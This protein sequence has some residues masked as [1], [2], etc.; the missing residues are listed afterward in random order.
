[1]VWSGSGSAPRCSP[2]AA[3]WL[4]RALWRARNLGFLS[5]HRESMGLGAA[6]LWPAVQARHPMA[7]RIGR[8]WRDG[9][10]QAV[11]ARLR[12]LS[13]NTQEQ[14]EALDD[15]ITYYT[16]HQTRTGSMP[17]SRP[18]AFQPKVP[19]RTQGV[20][21]ARLPISCAP[22][23][24]HQ[25]IRARHSARIRQFAEALRVLDQSSRELDGVAVTRDTQ[26]SLEQVASA[27]QDSLDLMLRAQTRGC[28]PP[29]S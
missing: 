2:P 5:R 27:R 20:V 10:V 16:D 9:Q 8:D 26:A 12:K 25:A 6:A 21:R 24:A 1:M 14:R 17:R 18:T 7:R 13:T 3:N 23:R 15:L 22:Q 11:I 29:D 4:M 19:R 28:L